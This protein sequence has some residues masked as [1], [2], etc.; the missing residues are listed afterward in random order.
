MKSVRA[1]LLARPTNGG[2]GLPIFVE[3]ANVQSLT[4]N[5]TFRLFHNELSPL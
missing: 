2:S 3:R 1:I 5:I 4:Q